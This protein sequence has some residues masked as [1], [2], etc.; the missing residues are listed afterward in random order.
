[1]LS[2]RKPMSRESK[3]RR[4]VGTMRVAAVSPQELR[5]EEAPTELVA[6]RGFVGGRAAAIRT[7]SLLI[8]AAEKGSTVYWTGHYE[9][10]NAAGHHS[11]VLVPS[12][13]CN[14]EWKP[15]GDKALH[16][17]SARV[18]KLIPRRKPV[19]ESVGLKMTPDQAL[20]L[21]GLLLVGAA[22]LSREGRKAIAVTAF[23]THKN[24]DGTYTTVT[25]E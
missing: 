13:Y 1:M 14:A 17:G 24:S 10:S 6:T 2:K 19:G 11:T 20:E 25:L 16:L 7:A 18:N 23:A 3:P 9:N 15:E 8:D 12:C 21:A 22:R 5:L 4:T